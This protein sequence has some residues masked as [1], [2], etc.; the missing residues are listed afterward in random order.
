M[1]LSSMLRRP[2]ADLLTAVEA[3]VLLTAFRVALRLVPVRRILRA[4]AHSAS[5]DSGVDTQPTPAECS[6]SE[7]AARRRV[8]WAVSAVSRHSPIEFVCFPQAL[9]GF[10]MLRRRGV[11]STILYG[12]RRSESGDLIAHAWLNTRDI[13][14]LG[15]EAAAGFTAIEQW[16]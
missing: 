16:S 13:N 12:V 9:A 4:I 2:P 15:G 5:A 8:Q 14:L 7:R 11:S 6:S 3:L 1:A 10:T